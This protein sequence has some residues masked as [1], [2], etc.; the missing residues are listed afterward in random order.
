MQN[1]LEF[2]NFYLKL[3]KTHR[4][5][6]DPDLCGPEGVPAPE[7]DPLLVAVAGDGEPDVAVLIVGML[8]QVLE[9]GFDLETRK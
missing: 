1:A 3:A 5:D 9:R 4:V 7:V 2:K 6:P 8:H